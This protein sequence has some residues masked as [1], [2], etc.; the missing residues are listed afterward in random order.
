MNS[1]LRLLYISS[2]I[3]WLYYFITY[4][5]GGFVPDIMI[6]LSLFISTF[7]SFTV[8]VEAYKNRGV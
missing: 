7:Y 6:P 3:I 5:L 4:C 2:F 8:L 1:L